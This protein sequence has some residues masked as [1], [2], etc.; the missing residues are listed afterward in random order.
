MLL[1][2]NTLYKK[3]QNGEKTQTIRTGWKRW[4]D[5]GLGASRKR[6]EAGMYHTTMSI[7]SVDRELQDYWK[8]PRNGGNLMG[9]QYLRKIK[10]CTFG[11]LTP[12]D[13]EYDGFDTLEEMR[14]ALIAR[15]PSIMNDTKVAVLT[16]EWQPDGGP[17]DVRHAEPWAYWG[18]LTKGETFAM[19]MREVG[20]SKVFIHSEV[21]YV[22]GSDFNEKYYRKLIEGIP[23]RKR[24]GPLKEHGVVE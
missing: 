24:W 6:I 9:F 2:F 15:N 7:D 4:W 22:T 16:F 17:W 19:V 13:A 20:R 14:V 23:R 1:T 3:L 10:I 8:N 12:L 5:W 18:I 21:G 11:D